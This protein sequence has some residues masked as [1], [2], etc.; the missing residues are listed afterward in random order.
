MLLALEEYFRSPLPETLASLYDAVNSMDLSLLPRLSLQE[1]FILQ[2]SDVKDL[3]VEKFEAM[4]QQRIA[5]DRN[6]QASSQTSQPQQLRQR[7]GLPRDTHEFESIVHYNNIPVP[8]KIPTSI[9][10][11][12]VGDFSLIK[13]IQT[14]ST[15]HASSPQPFTTHHPHLTTSGP[16]T[17]PIIVLINALL[18]QK[19]VIFMGHNLPSSDVAEGVLAAC[20]LASGGLLRGFTRHAFP[21]TDL[22]KIDDLLKV[23]GFIAGVTNPTFTHKAEWWDLLCDLPTGRMKISPKIEQAPLTEGLLSFQQAASSGSSGASSL[24][25]GNTGTLG[26][27]LGAGLGGTGFPSIPSGSGDPTGD[28]AFMTGVLAS[29]ADR[30]GEGAVRAKFRL[31]VSKFIRLAAAFEEMVYGASALNIHYPVPPSPTI[32]SPTTPSVASPILEPAVT[33]HGY[34]W[35]S[36]EAKMR[37]LAANATRIDGWTKTR[38]Y[39][40]FV[41]DFALLFTLQ[42]VQDLDLQHLHDKLSKLRLGSDASAA[43]Y[44]AICCRIDSYE[45]VNQ[46][47]SV[48]VNGS[49]LPATSPAMGSMSATSGLFYIALGLFHPRLDI[50]EAVAELLSRIRNHEAGRH[51]WNKLGR[52]EKAAWERVVVARHERVEMV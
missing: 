39:Y 51:F 8:V 36:Q 34:V 21:Y 18:T 3:F 20:A 1:R 46:L 19:R 32:T 45:Q 22:T 52:F 41:Q 11:E 33:G 16:L 7:Y 10:A 13:L 37:E 47:L 31:W 42:P 14:F 40:N 49:P 6:S 30:R 2:A 4:V 25:F 44:L 50:R 24:S 26:G 15:P 35:P 27:S 17:H 43:I 23:P 48:L 29:I 28:V 12:T 38:S 5:G 9:S